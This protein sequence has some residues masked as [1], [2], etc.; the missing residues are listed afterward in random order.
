MLKII[1][2]TLMV[3]NFLLLLLFGLILGPQTPMECVAGFSLGGILSTIGL[4]CSIELEE[5]REKGTD[6][7]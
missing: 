5:R 3:V 7:R 2:A 1:C 6:D 4:A